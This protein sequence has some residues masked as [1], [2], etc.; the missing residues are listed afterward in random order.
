MYCC[1]FTDWDRVAGRPPGSSSA[2]QQTMRNSATFPRLARNTS[3]CIDCSVN[4]WKVQSTN[5]GVFE[6]A[7]QWGRVSRQVIVKWK[8]RSRIVKCSARVSTE[9]FIGR[10][11]ETGA[12]SLR[13]RI[14]HET[15]IK[16]AV[17]CRAS[18]MN[19]GNNQLHS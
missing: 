10:R 14:Q 6:S 3:N 4:D 7:R 13:R 12:T 1:G 15:Q 18:G 2:N 11:H 17:I 8:P 5:Y 9:L 19:P 16:R